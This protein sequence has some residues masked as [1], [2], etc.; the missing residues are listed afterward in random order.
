MAKPNFNRRFFF[1]SNPD[2]KIRFAVVDG[3]PT[4]KFPSST[5][6]FTVKVFPNS[7]IEV[8]DDD[9]LVGSLKVGDDLP[10]DGTVIPY[11][12]SPQTAVPPGSGSGDQETDADELQ[13]VVAGSDCDGEALSGSPDVPAPSLAEGDARL[14]SDVERGPEGSPDGLLDG[15]NQPDVL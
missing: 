12:Q 5:S 6:W 15:S 8:F 1:P 2:S 11:E 10:P 13:Q 14:D 9:Q 4:Q 3:K 7:F